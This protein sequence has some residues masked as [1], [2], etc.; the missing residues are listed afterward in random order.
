MYIHSKTWLKFQDFF[1]A[2]VLSFGYEITRKG[3]QKPVSALSEILCPVDCYGSSRNAVA[4]AKSYSGKQ[5]LLFL[6][7]YLN[8]KKKQ[9]NVNIKQHRQGKGGLNFCTCNLKL[10]PLQVQ[11]IVDKVERI[12]GWKKRHTDNPLSLLSS[13][14]LL[15]LIAHWIKR[16]GSL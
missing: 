1:S 4:C 6:N 11:L 16:D 13:D 9:T 7:F 5:F 2:I 15:I 14:L 8:E 10:K 12:C 3:S